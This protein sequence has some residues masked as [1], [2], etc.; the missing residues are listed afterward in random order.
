M[1][2]E[3]RMDIENNRPDRFVSTGAL[4][5][6]P[7]TTNP[8][9]PLALGRQVSGLSKKAFGDIE[10]EAAMYG[11]MASSEANHVRSQLG[12]NVSRMKSRLEEKMREIA[13]IEK[14]IETHGR[15]T[16]LLKEKDAER[17]AEDKVM[18][19]SELERDAESTARDEFTS[20]SRRE[21]EAVAR[22]EEMVESAA[23]RLRDEITLTN[24]SGQ[25]R[26]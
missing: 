12:D 9:P 8:G 25:Q 3:I 18:Q 21:H 19:V 6:R 20:V 13:D 4:S 16:V 24:P 11:S 1:Y 5:R 26:Q 2:E 7:M 22:A 17:F 14:E 10:K 15:R 23:Q